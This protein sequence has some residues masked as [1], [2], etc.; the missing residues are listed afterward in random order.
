MGI[1]EATSREVVMGLPHDME[2][3]QKGTG[4]RRRSEQQGSLYI[5]KSRP[6]VMTIRHSSNKCDE[7]KLT[8]S[9]SIN[10]LHALLSPYS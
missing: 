2:I 7:K 8:G 4:S 3:E 9:R 10:K 1:A 6:A 5:Y